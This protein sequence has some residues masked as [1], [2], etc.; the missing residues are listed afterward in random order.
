MRVMVAERR[1]ILVAG[2]VTVL[3]LVLRFGPPLPRST[4]F[5]VEAALLAIGAVGVLGDVHQARRTRPQR[6]V[7][8]FFALG[9]LRAALL[10]SGQP[11]ARA[12]LVA[13][14]AAVA[15]GLAALARRRY[16]QRRAAG[17]RPARPDGAA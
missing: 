8:V 9:A 11:V 3:D 1:W 4:L 10:A 16:R 13:L 17:A 6:G 15:A 12:N 2:M 5:G 14:G 7:A